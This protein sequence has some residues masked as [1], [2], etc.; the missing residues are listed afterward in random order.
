[1]RKQ[2]CIVRCK[3]FKNIYLLEPVRYVWNRKWMR[4]SIID[5]CLIVV[6]GPTRTRGALLN[7]PTSQNGSRLPH[8]DDGVQKASK[9]KEENKRFP[10]R[11][12]MRPP[13]S[14]LSWWQAVSLRHECPG[15]SQSERFAAY[16]SKQ[17]PAAP[18][19]GRPQLE[20]TPLEGAS[21]RHGWALLLATYSPQII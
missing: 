9:K 18:A 16:L 2:A 6:P 17:V 8:V 21:Q 1:M 14:R 11:K 10:N 20:K 13:V 12:Q 7:I 5:S 15:T 3:T 19:H 4:V